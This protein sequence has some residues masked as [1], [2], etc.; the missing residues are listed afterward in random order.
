MRQLSVIA[1]LNEKLEV[2]AS[3]SWCG[4]EKIIS[5][6]YRGLGLTPARVGS[7]DTEDIHGIRKFYGCLLPHLGDQ[8]TSWYTEADIQKMKASHIVMG[9]PCLVFDMLNRRYLSPKYL[10][11][12]VLE[13][14]WWNAKPRNQRPGLWHI[15]KAWQQH[16]GGFSINCNAFWHAWGD[17]EIQS[18]FGFWS[19][20]KSWPWR[21]SASSPS[22]WNGKIGL[23]THYVTCMKCWPSHR[24]SYSSTPEWRLIGSLKKC[25]SQ[26]WPW[27]QCTEIGAKRIMRCYHEGVL[28]CL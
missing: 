18:P 1:Q 12:F 8:D 5:K 3:W 20:S 21:V 19:R 27:L 13:E 4:K 25:K 9:T 28:H 15:P 2:H 26:T 16:P 14:N 6:G 24:Q 17:Q 10:K 23:W 11:M 7:A 22:V